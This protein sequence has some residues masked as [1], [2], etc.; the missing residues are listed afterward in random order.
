MTTTQKPT[1]ETLTEYA[2]QIG[3][4]GGS[5]ISALVT[6]A[7]KTE[8]PTAWLLKWAENH[9]VVQETTKNG[10]GRLPAEP[11]EQEQPENQ[12]QSGLQAMQEQE[13]PEE[14]E[15]VSEPP[16]EV[17]EISVSLPLASQLQGYC[18]RHLDCQLSTEQGTVLKRLMLGFDQ[19][20]IRLAN[21]RRVVNQTDAIKKLLEILE[22]EYGSSK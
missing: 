11:T 13:S 19:Q 18:G 7:S 2:K 17:T 1:R 8:D 5:R 21:G 4:E 9:K 22:N 10:A 3:I 14:V 20:N 6:T 16:L 15:Q 12:P